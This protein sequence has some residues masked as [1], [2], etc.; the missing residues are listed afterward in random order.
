[1]RLTFDSGFHSTPST[2]TTAAMTPANATAPGRLRQ[3]GRRLALQV[4]GPALDN[5]HPH[6]LQ[7][8]HR[9]KDG[10]YAADRQQGQ[11]A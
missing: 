4:L 11:R 1:M 7:I 9:A 6:H 2:T 3:P 8:I 10:V 5:H